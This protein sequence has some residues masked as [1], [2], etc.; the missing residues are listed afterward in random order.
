MGLMFWG[1]LSSFAA[2]YKSERASAPQANSETRGLNTP[3]TSP[4]H[5]DPPQPA[6]SISPAVLPVATTSGA[7]GKESGV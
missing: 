2:V 6:R 1:I 5:L 3:R 4:W 7:A